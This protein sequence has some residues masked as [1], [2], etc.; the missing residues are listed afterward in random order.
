MIMLKR[1]HWRIEIDRKAIFEGKFKDAARIMIRELKFDSNQIDMAI[2]EMCKED[3]SG[4]DHDVA[5][6]GIYKRFM[7]SYN[8]KERKAG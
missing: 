1:D 4:P 5:H 3:R 2:K 6:F 7:F 8:S